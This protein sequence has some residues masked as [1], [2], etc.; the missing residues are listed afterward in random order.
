MAVETSF[1]IGPAQGRVPAAPGQMPQYIQFRLN[2]VDL[3]GPDVTVVDFVGASF[4]LTRGTG[5]DANKIT[6]SLG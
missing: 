3:G 4:V 6:V 2:G 5:A 1:A